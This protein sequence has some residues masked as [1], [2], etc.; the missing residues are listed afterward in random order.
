MP[1]CT[2]SAKFNYFLSFPFFSALSLPHQKS[3]RVL[4]VKRASNACIEHIAPLSMM[5]QPKRWAIG[6]PMARLSTFNNL[7]ISQGLKSSTIKSFFYVGWKPIWRIES[8]CMHVPLVCLECK[9]KLRV[10]N[11]RKLEKLT[12]RTAGC[13][14]SHLLHSSWVNY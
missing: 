6:C 14:L 2:A 7:V 8:F 5:A 3:L 12:T 10:R 9:L 1:Q 4:C 11:L 13:I